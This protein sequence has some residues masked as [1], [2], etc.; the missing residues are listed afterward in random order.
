MSKP[1]VPD[2]RPWTQQFQSRPEKVSV[3]TAA[4]AEAASAVA[5]GNRDTTASADGAGLPV[6]VRLQP[7]LL[8]R[9]DK[10][11]KPGQSR[12]AAIRE[13]LEKGLPE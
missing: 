10:V 9:L 3:E 8:A 2:K 7:D 6:T 1:P 5:S 11:V 4:K 13:F 12:P